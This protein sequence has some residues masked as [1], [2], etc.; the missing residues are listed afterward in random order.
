MF[1][2]RE[3]RILL[4]FSMFP[5]LYLLASEETGEKPSEELLGYFTGDLKYIAQYMRMF[6]Q[7]SAFMDYME[8]HD[9]L[10]PLLTANEVIDHWNRFVR[11]RNI[12]NEKVETEV[13][14]Q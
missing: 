10:S 3:K 14:G 4:I 7:F 6:V 13:I 8:E 11:I 5:L 9:A 2:E 12:K 1:S